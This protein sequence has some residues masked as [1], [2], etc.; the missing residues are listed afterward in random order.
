MKSA[1]VTGCAGF[2][3]SHLVDSLLA[4]GYFVIGMDNLQT[5][6]KKNIAHLAGN[7]NFTFILH[8]VISPYHIKA[9][10]YWNLACPASPPEYQRNPSHTLRTSIEGITSALDNASRTNAKVF[11]AS[12]SE[13]YGDPT[14]SEQSEDYWGNVNPN[15][16]R[17]CYDEGKRVAETIMCDHHRMHGT[18]IRIARIFNTYGVRMDKDDGRVVTN[19]VNQALRGEDITIYGQGQ[20]TRSF[21]YVDDLIRGFR[22]LM[23]SDVTT[24][25]N[26][27]AAE[28]FTMIELAEIVLRKTKSKS[29]L[30]FMPLPQDDPKRRKPNISRAQMFL[31]WGPKVSLDDGLDMTIDYFKGLM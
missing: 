19:F 12:T 27:G 16:I 7:Q 23:N 4:D 1:L 5:G 24:P 11:Q 22:L 9:D 21:C 13:V 18:D 20:Q 28:E 29:T 3:G 6:S 30:V 8:D 14:C 17:A 15:G 31:N 26:L 10:E 25:V 2:L